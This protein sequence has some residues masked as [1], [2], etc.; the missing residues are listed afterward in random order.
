[1][2]MKKLF[3]LSTLL[4]PLIVGAMDAPVKN[5]SIYTFA[6]LKNLA[7]SG[8]LDLKTTALLWDMSGVL[9]GRD[10]KAA[11]LHVLGTPWA[12]FMFF[13]DIKGKLD[14]LECA[15]SWV[16]TVAKYAAGKSW[17]NKNI[18]DWKQ[19]L[20]DLITISQTPD[21]A[22]IALFNKI[23]KNPDIGYVG[24]FSNN[25]PTAFE[26]QKKKPGFDFLKNTNIITCSQDAQAKPHEAA[27]TMAK[28]A[29][30]EKN[31]NIQTFILIDD[32]PENIKGAQDNGIYGIFYSNKDVNA[33]GHRI[34]PVAHLQQQLIDLGL[35]PEQEESTST[36]QS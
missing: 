18:E 17:L 4:L 10:K 14:D 5:Q 27:Y 11:A 12:T 2:E 34:T 23:K 13:S 31:Q 9:L 8:K 30:L 21:A 24:I 36:S 19:F 28:N 32:S 15:E 33:E 22:T 29:V 3:I 7:A 1:M 26:I 35:L 25:G 16:N 6:T 20:Y